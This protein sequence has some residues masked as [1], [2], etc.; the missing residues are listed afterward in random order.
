MRVF[1][2]LGCGAGRLA[3]LNNTPAGV[4][5]PQTADTHTAFYLS[6]KHTRICMR[7]TRDTSRAAPSV[8]ITP[9][10]TSGCSLEIERSRT[11]ISVLGGEF[12]DHYLDLYRGLS[13]D[14]RAR[15]RLYKTI[16]DA[17]KTR[18]ETLHSGDW[19]PKIVATRLRNMLAKQNRE[20]EE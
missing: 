8:Q 18:E 3:S 7:R 12:I 17:A 16:L 4:Y 15:T 6:H 5:S 1:C 13:G 2:Y 11:T 19:T 9:D 10:R 14:T 20:A